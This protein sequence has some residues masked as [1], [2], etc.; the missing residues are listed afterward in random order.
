[1]AE[2]FEDLI[3]DHSLE[4]EVVKEAFKRVEREKERIME[5]MLGGEFEL[6]DD[7]DI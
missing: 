5:V 4:D 6:I 3:L 1:M 7:E 2:L